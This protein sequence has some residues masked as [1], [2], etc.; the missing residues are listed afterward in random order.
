MDD[1][2][3][4]AAGEELRTTMTTIHAGVLDRAY[5]YILQV[6]SMIAVV[7]HAFPRRNILYIYTRCI[8]YFMY[9]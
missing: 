2:D 4:L 5:T 3:D 8:V 7:F 6:K 9:R 1:D